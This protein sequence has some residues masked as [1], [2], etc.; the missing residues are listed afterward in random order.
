MCDGRLFGPQITC[1]SSAH[2]CAVADFSTQD[3]IRAM[4]QDALALQSGDLIVVGLSMGG[5][6]AME[7]MACAPERIKALV[8]MSTNARA[9][10][11]E[12]AHAREP[13]IKAVR[14]GDMMGVLRRHY[15]PKYSGQTPLSE[16]I[17]NSCADMALDLGP[18]VFVRQS[19]ALQNRSDQMPELPKYACPVLV[20]CGQEDRLCPM[21]NHETM[22][23]LIPNA[24]LN[25]L[26]RCGHLPNL[27]EPQKINHYLQ[28][29]L[30]CQK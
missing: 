17:M 28:E 26:P 25:I 21:S 19:R 5:I 7:M 10:R 8:L 23:Q 16:D 4:A 6:V 22:V 18:D 13:H 27:E 1:L 30:A 3:S 29:F 2:P 12:V 15:F 9:E 11:P 24:I 20:I 14:Q